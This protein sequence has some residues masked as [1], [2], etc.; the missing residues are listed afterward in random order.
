[1]ESCQWAWSPVG[2]HGTSPSFVRLSPNDSLGARDESEAM[3]RF[4]SSLL[5]AVMLMSMLSC[6]LSNAAAESPEIV[7][8]SA[9]EWVDDDSIDTIVRIINGGYLTINGAKISMQEGSGF[10]IEAGGILILD[11]AELNAE[12]PPT[13][14]AGFG[15]WDEVNRSSILVRDPITTVHSKPRSTHRKEVRSTVAKHRWK[16][17][18]Q[19]ISMAATSPFHSMKTLATSGSD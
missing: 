6:G 2:G 18:K 1:M 9:V 3:K 8:D 19:S 5:T 11:N 16:G 10:I 13:G 4:Q 7:I 15:Y 12:N 14:L 17:A